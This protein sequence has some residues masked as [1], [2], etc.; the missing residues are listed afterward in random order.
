MM[1]QWKYE[2]IT[3]DFVV[4]LPRTREWNDAILVIVDWLTKSDHFLPVHTTYSMDQYAQLYI[5][6]IVRM[7]GIPKSIISDRD[8]RFT[9]TFWKSLHKEVGTSLVLST[10]FHPQSDGRSKITIQTLEDMLS[11]NPAPEVILYCTFPTNE[12]VLFCN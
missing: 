9:S 1:P 4:G 7:H 2:N 6:E 3:M 8:S 10:A 12:I 5:K 11:V